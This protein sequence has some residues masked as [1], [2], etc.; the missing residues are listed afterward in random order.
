MRWLKELLVSVRIG[1]ATAL[2]EI[3]ENRLRAVVTSVGVIMGVGG[4]TAM[5]SIFKGFEKNLMDTAMRVGGMERIAFEEKRPKGEKEEALFARSLRLGH[6]DLKIIKENADNID[7]IYP[8]MHVLPDFRAEYYY[9]SKLFKACIG[10]AFPDHLRVHTHYIGKGR[11]FD[12]KDM[13]KRSQV[14]IVGKALADNT[15]GKGVEVLGKRVIIGKYEFEVVGVMYEQV[16]WDKDRKI[17]LLAEKN[18]RAYIPYTTY[19]D[20]FLDPLNLKYQGFVMVKDF[21]G[22]YS[23]AEQI[24]HIL[25][26]AHNNVEDFKLRL[27]I[28]WIEDARNRTRI[29]FVIFMIISGIAML[30]SAIGILN[31]MLA[32]L[33]ERI[34]EIGVRKAIGATSGRI[35]LQFLCES[36][37]LTSMGGIFGVIFGL[38]PA[39]FIEGFGRSQ[40]TPVITPSVVVTGFFFCILTGLIA[41]VWPAIRAARLNPAEALIYE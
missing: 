24:R 36:V 17:N 12:I 23:T 14:M 4:I 21:K 26:K 9:K 27:N 1:Y 11:D 33:A 41:G 37:I 32:S 5:M 16:K 40:V 34:R 15:F 30:I 13:E 7:R 38:M 22:I 18:D 39:F 25:K 29:L 8:Y 10:A 3:S 19:V 31:I 35:F 2:R 6:R 20:K 28:E